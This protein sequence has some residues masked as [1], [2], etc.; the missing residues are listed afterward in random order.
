MTPKC[1][2]SVVLMTGMSSPDLRR[3]EDV[4]ALMLLKKPFDREGLLDAVTLGLE[5]C[6]RRDASGGT[7]CATR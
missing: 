3:L 6:R 7:A 4:G 5:H 1:G 2:V